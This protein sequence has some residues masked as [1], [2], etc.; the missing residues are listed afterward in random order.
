MARDYQYYFDDGL[1]T[2]TLCVQRVSETSQFFND[3]VVS[4]FRKHAKH[5][6]NFFRGQSFATIEDAQAY[7]DRYAQENRLLT[8][9]Q[10]RKEGKWNEWYE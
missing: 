4:L 10:A 6:I 2:G 5:G 9:T 1:I 3:Y 8:L 7:L